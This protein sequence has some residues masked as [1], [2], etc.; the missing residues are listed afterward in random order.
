M[1]ALVHNSFRISNAKQFKESFQELADFGIGKFVPTNITAMTANTTTGG[2]DVTPGS[3]T[4]AELDMIPSSALDDQIYLFIGRVTPWM[5][6]DTPDGT[7]DPTI[8]ENNPPDPVDSVKHGNF[9]H[10]DDMIA[11]KKVR[12]S[13]VSHVV[14][15]E[16]PTP[17]SSGVRGWESGTYYDEYDDRAA[18]LFDDDV[19]HHTLNDR[20]RVYKLSL[21][22]I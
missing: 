6:T 12:G 16:R 9:D 21:I 7:P 11:A 8:D 10:W 13:D 15:R 19:M 17:I 20:F 3:L 1:P 18:N 4:T 14:K 22:H 2:W 5:S